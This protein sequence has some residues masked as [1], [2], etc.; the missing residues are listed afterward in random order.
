M[1]GIVTDPYGH[2][3]SAGE[4]I[5]VDEQGLDL[6]SP[7]FGIFCPDDL[8]SH[9]TDIQMVDLSVEEHIKGNFVAGLKIAEVEIAGIGHGAHWILYAGWDF[10]YP[11]RSYGRISGLYKSHILIRLIPAFVDIP[12]EFVGLEGG[13][14]YIGLIAVPYFVDLVVKREG[15]PFRHYMIDV[16][17]IEAVQ[18]I[19]EDSL[20]CSEIGA[21]DC[22]IYSVGKGLS[23]PE[24][25]VGDPAKIIIGFQG[26]GQ[27]HQRQGEKSDKGSHQNSV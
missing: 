26:K 9:V 2:L 24:G 23:R 7:E 6:D 18:G 12:D 16:L 20:S 15:L 10:I 17:V 5:A 11:F 14:V 22:I 25:G 27:G 1:V 19:G 3:L 8:F 13:S 21:G 4:D